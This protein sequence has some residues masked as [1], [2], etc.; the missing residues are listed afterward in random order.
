MATF[1]KST[2]LGPFRLTASKSGLSVSGGVKGARVSVNSKGEVRRNL[3]IPG[4]GIYDSRKVGQLGGGTGQASA[5]APQSVRT[6]LTYVNAFGSS[7]DLRE[8]QDGVATAKVVGLKESV[9]DLAAYAGIQPQEYGGIHG[10]REVMLMP[11]R[12]QYT[13]LL[14]V[15]PEENRLLF[16]R[17]VTK[18]DPPRGVPIGRLSKVDMGKWAEAFA[19]RDIRAV[20]YLEARPGTNGTVQVRFKPELLA[21]TD[22]P[23]PAA[24][25]PLPEAG[26]FPDPKGEAELRWW[27]GSTWTE[28]VHSN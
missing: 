19:G 18:D 21:D 10:I 22:E 23:E 20:A 27:D 17:F 26:W 11:E 6:E 9:W 12:D 1:R 4:T 15:F 8:G 3:S 13:V 7:R 24:E 14:L 25:P 28:H 16:G 2:K 5:A